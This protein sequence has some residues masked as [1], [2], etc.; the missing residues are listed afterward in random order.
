M[1]DALS[2]SLFVKDGGLLG[3]WPYVDEAVRLHYRLATQKNSCVVKGAGEELGAACGLE[4]A[5]PHHDLSTCDQSP[6]YA[7][8]LTKCIA[9]SGGFV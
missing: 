1:T 7:R 8:P 3:D 5:P 4:A 2:I 9:K 6:L